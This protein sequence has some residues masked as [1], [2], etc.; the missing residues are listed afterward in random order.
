MINTMDDDSIVARRLRFIERQQKLG[1]GVNVRFEGLAPAGSGPA[2]RHGLPS[3]PVDQRVVTNWPVLDLGDVPNISLS[4]WRLEL[5]GLVENPVT[6]TWEAF[7][8]LPQV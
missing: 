7:L 1:H 5:G 8:A 2:N 6:L 3:V 4:E